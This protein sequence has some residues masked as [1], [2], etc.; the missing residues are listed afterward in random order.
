[1][2]VTVARRV[3]IVDE[4]ATVLFALSPG[5]LTTAAVTAR[6]TNELTA[7][8]LSRGWLPRAEARVDIPNTSAG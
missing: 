5:S 7:W 4:L 3:T 2:T 8:A 1:M 6:I